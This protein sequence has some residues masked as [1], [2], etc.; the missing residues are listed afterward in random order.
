MGLSYKEIKTKNAEMKKVFNLG[1]NDGLK[2]IAEDLGSLA[3]D[4]S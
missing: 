3:R 4:S 1:D 2:Q